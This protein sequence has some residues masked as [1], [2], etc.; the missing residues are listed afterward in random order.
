MAS[1]N[2]L[3]FLIQAWVM[4]EIIWLN[5]LLIIMMLLYYQMVGLKNIRG[6]ALGNIKGLVDLNFLRQKRGLAVL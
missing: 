1:K 3:V 6:E 5:F 4:L 2:S